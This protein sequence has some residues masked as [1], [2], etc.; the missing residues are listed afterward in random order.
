VRLVLVH[1][2]AEVRQLLRYPTYALPTLLFPA[3]LM[4]LFGARL[5]TEDR[6]RL[7]AGVCATAVL[8]VAFFQF[9]VGIAATREST[10]ERYVRTLPVRPAARLA[11]RVLAALGFA[12]ASAVVVALVG[13]LLLDARLDAGRYALLALALVVGGIPF[14]LLGI[15]LGYWLRPRA[16]LPVANL[17]YLPLAIAGS[18]WGKPDDVPPSLDDVSQTLPTRNWMEILDPLTAQSGT[19]PFRHVAALAAW[20]VVFAAFAWLAYRRDEGERY[21]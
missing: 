8:A 14:A 2:W 20:S 5:E 11:A 15:G 7:L 19:V 10:W 4:L 13:A 18:L 6:A 16:A 1:A 9:G 21:S 17:L 12:L 3:L